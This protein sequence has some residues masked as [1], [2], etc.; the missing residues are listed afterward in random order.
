[1][2]RQ[3]AD[4]GGEQRH[5]QSIDVGFRLIRA[6]QEA[7]S[8]TM[9]KTLAGM[10]AMPPAKAHLY[11]VS[12]ARLGLVVQDM[13]SLRYSLGPYAVQLG[14]SAIR[15]T[16]V[17]ELAREPMQTLQDALR[18]PVFLSVW[19]NLGP[20]IVFKLDRNTAL[21]VTMKIG[22]VLPLNSATGKL[23]FAHLPLSETVEALARHQAALPGQP[24]P[25]DEEGRRDVRDRN[26]ASSRNQVNTGFAAISSGVFD[27][28]GQI[29]AAVTTI[30]FAEQIDIGADGR[31]V[32]LLKA[33]TAAIAQ[34]LGA[35]PRPSP[36]APGD[37][38]GASPSA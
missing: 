9:L 6:L 2:I 28:D 15:Q 26:L 8:G 4:G 30:G 24:M 33:A 19:G 32:R 12:F 3:R 22:F 18:L 31:P 11:M 10:A 35:R 20:A 16:D 23:F 34:A 25:A 38:Q 7:G 37:S 27:H 1:M 21:P 29:A 14:L 5:I 17:V 36:R 13:N